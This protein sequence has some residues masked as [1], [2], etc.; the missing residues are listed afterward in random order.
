MK[1]ELLQGVW[2]DELRGGEAEASPF[3]PAEANGAGPRA[4]REWIGEEP[5]APARDTWDAWLTRAASDAEDI[6][7]AE[8]VTL[9]PPVPDSKLVPWW[10]WQEEQE[11]RRS[12]S[13]RREEAGERAK[14]ARAPALVTPGTE[15]RALSWQR[16]SDVQMRSIVFLDKPLWQADAFHLVVGR[17]GVGKGTMLASLAA[18]VTRGELGEKRDVLWI[19]SEDSAAIDIHPRMVA[20]GGDPDRVFVVEK[21]WLQL[22]RDF[23][24]LGSTIEEFDGVG[25]VI[26]DPLGNHIT[27][28]DSNSDTDI[29]DA[30]APLND[31]ADKQET[32]I[33][34][35]RHLTEKEVKAGALGAILGA[36]AWV[37]V[38]RAVIGLARDDDDTSVSHIQCIAGNRLPPD[39]PGRTFQIVG[40]KL[41][42]LENEVTRAHWLGDSSKDIETLIGQPQPSG[43]RVPAEQVREVILR[44]LEQG[45]RSRQQLDDAVKTTT[46]ANP[47]SVYKSG[48]GPLREEGRIKARKDGP[49][50]PWCWRLSL[51]EAGTSNLVEWP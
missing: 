45:E 46:G 33:V 51:D 16:L 21:G 6:P 1:D 25:L 36:S 9:P 43:R 4:E 23:E 19:G 34:G 7:F 2:P 29:R 47:D 48:L 35:I 20:A 14:P 40:E 39:T 15:E 42:E 22:P 49:D 30:I 27:G 13:R 44:E 41:P 11:R 31:L 32:M 28:K 38:P 26:I 12:R 50:G 3:A 8:G 37:Q 5:P 10:E 24:E 17:K 18:H